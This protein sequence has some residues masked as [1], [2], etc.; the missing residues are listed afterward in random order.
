MLSIPEVQIGFMSQVGPGQSGYCISDVHEPPLS[1]NINKSTA[2]FFLPCV[3]NVLLQSTL[4]RNTVHILF[5]WY[6]G[7]I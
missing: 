3:T 4:Q 5:E 6:D 1:S 7:N 2:A